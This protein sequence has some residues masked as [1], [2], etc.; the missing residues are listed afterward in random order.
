MKTGTFSLSITGAGGGTRTHTT[1]KSPDFESGAST[2]FTT[3]AVSRIIDP[4]PG[5]ITCIYRP[6]Q[7][8]SPH[9]RC[10]GDSAAFH[11]LPLSE[12]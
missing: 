5:E 10:I 8:Y 1:R 3:P 7:A 11:N 9:Q 2:N 6:G 12:E 4:E